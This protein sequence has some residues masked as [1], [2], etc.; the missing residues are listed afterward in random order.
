MS[1]FQNA[2][3]NLLQ[4]FWM[5][6]QP[7]QFLII[8]RCHLIEL[9]CEAWDCK[10]S[11][12]ILMI[13]Y[14][15]GW[16]GH[17]FLWDDDFHVRISNKLSVS[18]FRTTRQ[19]WQ[20]WAKCSWSTRLTTAHKSQLITTRKIMWTLLW[21]LLNLHY[22]HQ[23]GTRRLKVTS[24]SWVECTSDC[25]HPQLTCIF[26]ALE[27]EPFPLQAMETLSAHSKQPSTDNILGAHN[28]QR[29]HSRIS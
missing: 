22:L 12:S 11:H 5:T 6:S 29:S 1:I 19:D 15:G 2:V 26:T 13:L 27:S 20:W 18:C 4:L 16:I 28:N 3:V 8:N 21:F 25:L 9:I 24:S 23:H 7:V 14:D 10:Y 17:N